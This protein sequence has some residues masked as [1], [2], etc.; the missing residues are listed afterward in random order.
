MSEI[1]RL[2]HIN[3]QTK[4]VLTDPEKHKSDIE[5]IL[6]HVKKQLTQME[7]D[8]LEDLLTRDDVRFR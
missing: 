8:E 6:S 7:Q 5:S 2:H 3:L 4:N 1:A